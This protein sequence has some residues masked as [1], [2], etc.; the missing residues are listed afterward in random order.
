MA[1]TEA[2]RIKGEKVFKT[3]LSSCLNFVCRITIKP[4]AATIKS[5]PIADAEA[6]NLDCGDS[7]TNATPT[8][9]LAKIAIQ[10]RLGLFRYTLK[11]LTINPG[12]NML[13]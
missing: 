6:G 13:G 2:I 8:T 11:N 12:R 9:S 10:Y 7:I 4:T 3:Q 1:T 5:Q